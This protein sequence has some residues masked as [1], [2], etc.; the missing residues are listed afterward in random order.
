L[1][2]LIVKKSDTF[3]LVYEGD[4]AVKAKKKPHTWI[5][6]EQAKLEAGEKPDV[7]VA[8]PLGSDEVLRIVNALEV[9]PSLVISAASLGVVKI[10]QADGT[11]IEEAK[12]IREILNMAQNLEAITSLAQTIFEA[13]REGLDA[14]PFRG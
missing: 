6:E 1:A 10:E 4:P 3:R 5:P 14:L 7:I 9:D 8:R 11:T 12:E 13:S 2:F